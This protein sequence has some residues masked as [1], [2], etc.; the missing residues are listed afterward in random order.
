VDV[1]LG[2]PV[3]LGQTK[4]NDVHLST[5]KSGMHS[6]SHKHCQME[7]QNCCIT[8]RLLW[9]QQSLNQLLMCM[10]QVILRPLLLQRLDPYAECCLPALDPSCW[11]PHCCVGDPPC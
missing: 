6:A 7:Q 9:L 1:A 10:W 3:L 2:V 8:F 4:V 5:R 11:A